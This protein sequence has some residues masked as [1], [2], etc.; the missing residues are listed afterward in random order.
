MQLFR[1][2]SLGSSTLIVI[3]N[4]IGVGIFT[5]SG[6]VARDLGES[7][8]L[9]G[10]WLLG[11]ALA[12]MGALCYSA[13]VRETPRAGGEYAFL[14]PAFGPLI[15]FYAGWASLLIGFSATIA[16][17]SIGLVADAGP[18]RPFSTSGELASKATSVVVLPPRRC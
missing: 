13:L 14:Y 5:T 7:R 15:A 2:I 4:I 10:V 12:L 9:I 17:G 6:L 11:G 8:W 18:L 16:A 3:G 1:E